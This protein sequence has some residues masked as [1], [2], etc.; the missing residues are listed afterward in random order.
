MKKYFKILF[1][2]LLLFFL[3]LVLGELVFRFVFPNYQLYQR[4]NPNQNKNRTFTLKLNN[5]HWPKEDKM[6]GWVCNSDSF[7]KF[8][9]KIYN[10]LPIKYIINKDGFRNNFDFCQTSIVDST[11]KVMLIGDSFIMSVYLSEDKTIASNIQNA[12]GKD[13]K[14]I[15]LG[16]PGYGI[17]QSILTYQKFN[18]LLQPDIVVLFYIDDDIVR[19]LEAFRKAEGMNKPSYCINNDSLKLRIREDKSCLTSLFENSYLLNRFY[20]KYMHYYSIDLAKKM[21][22]KI[23]YMTKNYNQKLIIVRCPVIEALI[24]KNDFNFYSLSDFL[25]ERN[26]ENIELYYKMVNLPPSF[27]RT[28]YLVNDGHPSEIGAKYFADVISKAVLQK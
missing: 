5:V 2:N 10:K 26:I 9:N 1:F 27:L 16:I 15:N 21:L 20:R 18:N 28:I 23:I 12:L 11:R 4:T 8:S 13:Y 6:L 17:D 25:K 7:L 22:E 3:L 14:I 24:N 19:I